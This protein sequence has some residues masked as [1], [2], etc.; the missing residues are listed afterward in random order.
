MLTTVSLQCS[1]S[2]HIQAIFS[3]QVGPC[4]SAAPSHAFYNDTVGGFASKPYS[5]GGDMR[6]QVILIIFPEQPE[7]IPRNRLHP[8]EWHWEGTLLAC[9]VQH[10]ARDMKQHLLG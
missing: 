6:R 2:A 3:E 5:N 9:Q 8:L 4:T 7:Q 1:K 10:V